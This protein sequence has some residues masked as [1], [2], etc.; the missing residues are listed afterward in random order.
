MKK[1]VKTWLR[2]NRRG[3]YIYYLRWIGE[4]GREKYQ[5]LGHPDKREAERQRREKELDLVSD[6]EQPEKMKLSELLE[7]YLEWTRTQIEPSTAKTAKYCMK[8]FIAAIG[9]IY[10]DGVTYKHC[11][12]FHQYCVDRGLRPASVNT[13]IKL[14]KR[15]FSLAV[16]RGQLQQNPFNGVPLLKVPKKAVRVFSKDEFDRI[17]EATH[18]RIWKARILLAKTA[19]LRK[20]EVLNLTLNDVDF[21]KGKVIVQPKDDTKY[22]WRWVVK[23]KDRRELPLVNQVAQLLIDIQT[24]LPE[25]QPY[26]LLPPQRYQYL[27]R[28][29]AK[30]E[31]RWE[32]CKCPDGNFGR[33]WRMIFKKA[34]I[35][36]G[37]TFHDLR[38][39]CITEWLEK[40][41]LPHEV[42]KLAGHADINT[43][44]NYYVGIRESLIDRARGASNAALGE[45][46]GAL[47]VRA[48][49]N[50]RNDKK[51]VLSETSQGIVFTKVT[52]S[53]DLK[54]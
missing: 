46:S 28:L 9:D 38:S 40:G 5:S 32:M 50:S 26:L 29:K 54:V 12:R 13:H 6:A 22:T 52:E 10:A 7:D 30:G 47:L 17:L 2:R 3:T 21:A 39:T 44:M 1:L 41:L 24:E 34:G 43:T 49:Q 16:K 27:M 36:Y 4:D 51:T 23:D 20:G 25:G 15:I 19:G 11:E 48:A 42:K 33:S 53:Q 8:D 45:D 31:L 18:S 14:I 35:E 37:G